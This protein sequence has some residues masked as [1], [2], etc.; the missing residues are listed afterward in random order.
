MQT[1]VGQNL[2]KKPVSSSPEQ[3]VQEF[4]LVVRSGVNPERTKDFMADKV[5]AHQVNAESPVT[6]IRTPQNYTDHVKEFLQLYGRFEFE[7][8]ELIA[9][10]NK[11]YA[12]WKQTGKHLADIDGYKATG[13]PL[14]EFASAV[15]L[16]ENGK[17]T[18]YWI[19][20]DR[21]G[22]EQQLKK[23]AGSN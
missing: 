9:Q 14:V 3:L 21:M 5:L 20:V 7:I 22:M 4:L 6:V 16:V 23:N 11:V 8:T 10:G 2:S 19:Q 17:I 18:E 1:V 13:L 15:Y 12:R